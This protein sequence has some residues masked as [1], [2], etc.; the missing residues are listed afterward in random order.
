M[1]KLKFTNEEFKEIIKLR[2]RGYTEH[3]AI[4]MY[5]KCIRESIKYIDDFQGVDRIRG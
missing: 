4:E 5:K 3:E 1:S 2:E